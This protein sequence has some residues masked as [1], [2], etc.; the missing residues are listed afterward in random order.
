[1]RLALMVREA[2]GWCGRLAQPWGASTGQTHM[3]Q[4]SGRYACV[5]VRAGT[6]G[7][8]SFHA[9]CVE[10]GMRGAGRACIG[11]WEFG[12]CGMPEGAGWFKAD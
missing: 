11:D 2:R 1:M 4:A 5:C 6:Y 12:V 3:T 10:K 9:V 8:R 7:Y